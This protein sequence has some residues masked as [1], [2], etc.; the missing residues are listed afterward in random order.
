MF[1]DIHLD[2]EMASIVAPNVNEDIIFIGHAPEGK[3][4]RISIFMT[5]DKCAL[6]HS[7]VG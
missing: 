7:S 6:F 4:C 5:V 1:K 3:N 2:L